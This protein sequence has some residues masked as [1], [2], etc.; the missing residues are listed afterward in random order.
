MMLLR[1]YSDGR[2][3]CIQFTNSNKC[4]NSAYARPRAD[5]IAGSFGEAP[6]L[7]GDLPMVLSFRRFSLFPPIPA[8]HSFVTNECLNFK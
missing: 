4:L 7:Y 6:V 3:M 2:D 1:V 5:A 8:G